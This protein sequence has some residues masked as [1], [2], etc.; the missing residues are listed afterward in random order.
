M[1]SSGGRQATTTREVRRSTLITKRTLNRKVLKT[2][3][4]L[5]VSQRDFAGWAVA[6][7]GN[8]DLDGSFVLA[9]FIHFRTVQKHDRVRILLDAAALAQV[10]Q[11]RLV[12]LAVFRGAIDLG[13]RQDGDLQLTRQVLQAARDGGDLLL[14]AVAAVV[15]L[16]Q[17]Q[18]V[19]DHGPNLVPQLQTA[20][21]GGDAEHVERRR[22]V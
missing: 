20:G 1:D 11:A 18:V 2:H 10:G 14:P 16:N 13:Q 21:V 12:V 4:L 7:L 5:Q 15:R 8:H 3:E 17:L 6:L 22:I 9:G 19:D